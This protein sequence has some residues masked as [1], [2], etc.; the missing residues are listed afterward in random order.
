MK[1]LSMMFGH[2]HDFAH[3]LSKIFGKKRHVA[4][5]TNANFKF[6]YFFSF[7]LTFKLIKYKKIKRK[8]S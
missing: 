5:Y 8:K 6:V 3:G 2:L 1:L 4:E 7:N